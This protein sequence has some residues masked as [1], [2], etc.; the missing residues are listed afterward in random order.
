MRGLEPT[1][2]FLHGLRLEAGSPQSSLVD[3]RPGVCEGC[4]LD[5]GW[6][7]QRVRLPVHLLLHL[8]VSAAFVPLTELMVYS[9]PEG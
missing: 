3:E 2:P 6:W 1:P 4:V 9:A 7:C 5:S 8:L